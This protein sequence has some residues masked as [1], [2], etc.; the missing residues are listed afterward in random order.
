M[1]TVDESLLNGDWYVNRGFNPLYDCYDCQVLTFNVKDGKIDYRALFNMIAVNQTEIWVTANMVGEDKS[2][3]GILQ[4]DGEENGLP[5]H[6]SWYMMYLDSETLISY[7]CGSVLSWHFE[8]LLIMSKTMTLNPDRE[9]DIKRIM[10]ELQITDD[11]ICKLNP[12]S[13]CQAKPTLFT[14]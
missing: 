11:Q 4:M 6:Q 9:A 2:T 12:A 14:Q 1:K 13:G 7:Y 5:D 10:A 8:G 3:P